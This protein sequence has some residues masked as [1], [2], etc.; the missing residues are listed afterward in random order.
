MMLRTQMLGSG[1]RKRSF[2][3][4]HHPNLS[5]QSQYFSIKILQLSGSNSKPALIINELFS[6]PTL[7]MNGINSAF[8]ISRQLLNI[9]PRYLVLFSKLE[10]CGHENLLQEA[11]LINKTL[12]LFIPQILFFL[13]NIVIVILKPML[14]F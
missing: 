5:P 7:C 11:N 9:I 1:K 8:K 6:A 2:F 13:N 14:N 10:I 3:I 12:V 4:L